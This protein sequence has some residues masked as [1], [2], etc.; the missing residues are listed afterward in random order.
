[1]IDWPQDLIKDI[2]R[3]RAILFLGAGV[4]KNS[5]G[6]QGKR[7]PLWNEFLDIG[8]ERCQNPKRHIAKL[9]KERDYLSACELLKERLGH[10]FVALLQ[11]EFVNPR[12]APSNIH[13]D[14]FKLD[15]R[16]VLTPNFDKIYDNFAQ[17]E[18]KGTV[19]VKRYYDSDLAA[20]V[21]GDTRVIIK[22]HGTVDE[23][24]KTIFTRRQ[25][26]EAR[27]TF[28][29]FY[30]LLDALAL[31]HTLVFLGAGLNDPDIRLLLERFAHVYP[32]NRHHY[33]IMPN[34]AMHKDV[35]NSVTINMN[36]K[37][38]SYNSIDNHK[39]LGDSIKDLVA[40]VENERRALST[41]LDW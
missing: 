31:T 36:L 37:F 13:G 16:I 28:S 10:D 24:A 41:T 2:A 23:M 8:L 12:Y 1:M 20:Y 6:D 18:S 14:I 25:Y 11:E 29:G 35:R 3:R 39:E 38:L 7:P 27:Y 34:N 17:T 9:L 4:S 30:S 32:N 19:F 22:V 40:K 5:I 15:A 33:I 21:R 26:G